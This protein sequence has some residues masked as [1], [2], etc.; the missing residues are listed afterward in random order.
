MEI[1]YKP[2][3][4]I[5]GI[6]AGIILP[7]CQKE[8]EKVSSYC[9][10]KQYLVTS[11]YNQIHYLMREYQKC[12]SLSD[13]DYAAWEKNYNPESLDTRYTPVTDCSKCTALIN[14]GLFTMKVY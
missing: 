14:E 3:G 11:N 13:L 12:E 10:Y 9:V 2:L 5:A 8:S 4:I 6:I 1:S 7:S